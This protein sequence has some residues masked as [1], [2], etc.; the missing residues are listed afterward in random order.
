MIKAPSALVGSQ[1]DA[2]MSRPDRVCASQRRV[3]ERLRRAPGTCMTS[4]LVTRLLLG[5]GMLRSR[6][7]W[8]ISRETPTM[9]VE[10]KRLLSP[11]PAGGQRGMFL[12]RL[13]T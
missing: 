2:E 7:P 6:V 9:Q 4:I 5:V 10:V 13:S 3:T 12:H 11:G 8:T 1:R